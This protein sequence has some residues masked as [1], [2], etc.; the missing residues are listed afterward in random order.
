MCQSSVILR[1]ADREEE[2]KRDVILVEPVEGGVKIQGFFESPQV[3]PAR[4]ASIDLLK[5]RIILE[6][7]DNKDG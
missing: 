2:I 5:H 6:P 7:L 4:I 1:S 3:I